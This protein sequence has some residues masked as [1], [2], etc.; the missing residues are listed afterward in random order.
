MNPAAVISTLVKAEGI[1]PAIAQ[2]EEYDKVS[3][4]TATS[5]DKMAAATTA[6]GKAAKGSRQHISGATK[7]MGGFL[8]VVGGFALVEKSVHTTEQ[9]A[10]EVAGL[11]KNFGLS[12]KAASEWGAVMQ[13]RGVD[14]KKLAISFKSLSTAVAAGAAGSKTSTRLFGQLGISQKS[15]KANGNDLNKVLGLVSDG[16]EKLPAGTNK[17]AIMAK[18]FGRS[19][20][21]IAPLIRGGSKA[22][23]EQLGTADKY[24]A[25]LTGSGKSVE[26][27]IEQQRE[28]KLASMGLQLQLGQALIPAIT[29]VLGV[30]LKL[31]LAFRTSPPA[32]KIAAAALIG[33][34]VA[35]FAV[36]AV[37]EANPIVRVASL[38]ILL[39]VA[40]V[41]A[42]K[43]SASFRQIIQDVGSTLV[44]VWHAIQNA[45][46]PVVAWLKNAW[47]NVSHALIVAWGALKSAANTVFPI[48]SK[49]ATVA[50][51]LIKIA[52]DVMKIQFQVGMAIIKPL[53]VNGFKVIMAII[54]NFLIPAFKA[55]LGT[56]KF[57]TTPIRVLA[58]LFIDNF[59]SI[60]RAVGKAMD[61][62]LGAF[63]TFLGVVA[64]VASVKL[65]FLGKVFG[66]TGDTIRH[67]SDKVNDL[68]DDLKG[69]PKKSQTDV[70][71]NIN[72]TSNISNAVAQ[73]A[74]SVGG[75]V[76]GVGSKVGHHARGGMVNTPGYFAGEEAPRHPEVIISTNPRDR[77]PN[78]GYWA[79]AGSMLGVPGFAKGGIA[80][81]AGPWAGK[82]GGKWMG[83]KAVSWAKPLAAQ[84][85]AGGS[86]S[87]MA[88]LW[89]LGG[90]PADVATIAGAI[91]MAESGGRNVK[92]QGQPYSSTGWGPWQIT[93]GNSEPQYGVDA[94]LLVP[95]NNAHAAVAKYHQAGNSFSPWTTFTSGAYRKFLSGTSG[96]SLI[97]AAGGPAG[98]G[99]YAGLPMADW[100]I[101]S[102]NYAGSKGVRPTPTSGYRPGVDPHTAS[103]KSEHQGI[104]Y[105]HGA[106]DFGSPTSG[107]AAK[108]SVVN[109]TAGYKWPLIAP[110]GFRDDGHASG[111]GHMKGGIHHFAKGGI[112]NGGGASQ[113]ATSGSPHFARGGKYP[114]WPKNRSQWDSHNGYAWWV[115]WAMKHDKSAGH[116][117]VDMG[118]GEF[119]ND[120]YG[121]FRTNN[122]SKIPHEAWN[123]WHNRWSDG[124][125]WYRKGGIHSNKT[126]AFKRGGISGSIP[127]F[128]TGGT[129]SSSKPVRVPSSGGG[130]GG[131]PLNGGYRQALGIPNLPK[132]GGSAG[133][134]I[135]SALGI[136]KTVGGIRG[137]IDGLGHQLDLMDQVFSF[138]TE[139]FLN[140]DGTRNEKAIADRV[141]ELNK[142]AAIAKSIFA[143]YGKLVIY[144]QR[145]VATYQNVVVTLQR[146]Q[147]GALST[148]TMLESALG[149]ISTKGLKGNALKS[150][151][152]HQAD[153]KTNIKHY[154]GI[155]TKAGTDITTYK[156]HISDYS[157]QITTAM[158]DR[159]SSWLNWQRYLQE[160]TSV[161]GTLATPSTPDTTTPDASSPDVPDVS[162][163]DTSGSDALVAAAQG[164]ALQTKQM[165]DV[166][167]AQYGVLSAL[168][169]YGGS[170]ADGGVVP[171]PTGAP[172]MIIAHGGEPVGMSQPVQVQVIVHDGAVDTDKIEVIATNAA[173]KVTRGQSRSG[174]QG[175]RLPGTRR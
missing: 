90:G 115:N 113:S 94:A 159:D 39:G 22:M 171:G 164:I 97:G 58:G 88:S 125:T 37:M 10:H 140:E 134:T 3:K 89:T 79:A 142:L 57:L 27:M 162:T 168:P 112:F 55:L 80:S 38:F 136:T 130:A 48:I 174:V 110:I 83:G 67:L 6:Q 12:K 151:T 60:R 14:S 131:N 9:F 59:T 24:G 45:A 104:Q 32:V 102:L 139:D 123:N 84:L 99:T 166:S 78:L 41:A 54:N 95:I 51:D 62:V 149:H 85:S 141:G 147:S 72:F 17:A 36:N 145:L 20:L 163:P 34:S 107:L 46:I 18:L 44:N 33:L 73:I 50:F 126:R 155:A 124:Y 133:N 132:I 2:L 160:K 29:A 144:L 114:S 30:V 21:Q 158:D 175:S 154:Q 42:Y 116:P 19:W 156:G 4:K 74:A 64:D 100:V 170:F 63:S 105:P 86:S 56:I 25:T 137:S 77:M 148:V 81:G 173:V 7:A 35:M 87:A 53:L 152:K 118:S 49:I 98:V 146:K 96:S 23:K 26:K 11:Q 172:R 70:G 61:F 106:V 121:Y 5:S 138:S 128:K 66:S 1:A 167:Q 117:G 47:T 108:M 43:K 75:S 122:S 15:L 28:F 169:P 31:M 161:A 111:T 76:V 101:S 40:L 16:L 165:Y 127:H 68:R 91:A 150:A 120:L 109:A 92:Q 103:G 135:G 69:I 143:D 8:A 13:A 157:G 129:F 93:P 52:F 65:P 82:T 153:L 71:V 119:Y